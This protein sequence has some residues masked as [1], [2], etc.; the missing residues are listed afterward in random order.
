M[1]T[2][3]RYTPVCSVTILHASN[4]PSDTILIIFWTAHVVTQLYNINIVYGTIATSIIHSWLCNTHKK[5]MVNK[6]EIANSKTCTYN[7]I[8]Q[9]ECMERMGRNRS[10]YVFLLMAEKNLLSEWNN[11]QITYE[12]IYRYR[13]LQEQ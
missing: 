8:E 3:S 13:F 10:E 11:V 1:D 2:T 7:N 9:Q 4:F 5:L 6:A 12:Q